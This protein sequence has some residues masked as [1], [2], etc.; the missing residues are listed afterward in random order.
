MAAAKTGDIA[1]ITAE[2]AGASAGAVSPDFPPDLPRS[3]ATARKDFVS[4]ATNVGRALPPKQRELSQ[5]YQQALAIVDAKASQTKDAA[6]TAAV[7]AEKQRV[8]PQIEAMHGG[9]KHQ[10]VVE[11]GDF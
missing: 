11:N 6:L 8:L 3:L 2:L 4:A 7:A 10:N 5:K 9:Q 1:A